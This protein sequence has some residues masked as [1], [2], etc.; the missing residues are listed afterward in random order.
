MQIFQLKLFPLEMSIK[1]FSAKRVSMILTD[2]PL[3]IDKS[4]ICVIDR[5]T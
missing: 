3:T 5:L 1:T 4:L 2:S